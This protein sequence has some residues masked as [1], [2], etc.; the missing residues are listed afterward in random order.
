[1]KKIMILAASAA[2]VLAAG[3]AKN[4]VFTPQADGQHA[5]GFTNYAP[6]QITKADATYAA[7]TSLVAAKKFAVYSYAT[8]NGT[9]FATS[10]AGALGTKFMDKVAVTYT[11]NDDNGANNTYSPLRYWPSGDTPEWLTFWAYYPVSET[12]G[13]AV[14]PTNGINYTAPDGSNDLGSFAFTAATTA[15]TM[16]DFMV[17][18]VVNDKIYGTAAGSHVAVNGVVPFTFRHQLSKIRFLINTDNTDATTKVVLTDAKLYNVKT[19]GVLSAEYDDGGTDTSWGSVD[20]VD[21]NT[22]GTPDVVYELTNGGS[23]YSN[24]V[25]TTTSVGDG[26]ADIFL[27]VPQDM[28]AYDQTNPQKIVIT[29]DVKTFDTSE[30]AN[31]NGAT[32]TTVGS[33]GLLAITHNSQVIFLDNVAVKDALDNPAS[34]DWAKNQFTTYAITVGPKPIRFTATVVSWDDETTGVISVN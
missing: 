2:L 16:V 1:M 17:A 13:V 25:L 12:S 7:S 31:N 15:A 23:D 4:E 20:F 21:E 19:T 22:D 24:E 6:K 34:N 28:V 27:M 8:A 10:S 5:I 32:A 30:N 11:N 3:C 14:N 26:N 18:D 9:A 33:N 29:W